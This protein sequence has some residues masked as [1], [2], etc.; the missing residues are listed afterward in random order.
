MPSR[1]T[2]RR[3]VTDEKFKQLLF[4]KMRPKDVERVMEAYREAED[5]HGR[6]SQRRDSG[7][8][9]FEHPK[10]VAMILMLEFEIYDPDMVISALLHDTVEDTSVFG[11]KDEAYEI[12]QRK[13]NKRVANFVIALSKESCS[14]PEKK[15][16]R[17]MRYFEAIMSEGPLTTI[18]KLA[19]KPDNL[20]SLEC[21]T[22]ERKRR[23]IAE[24]R[25]YILPMA[26]SVAER[27][28]GRIRTNLRRVYREM[29][30]ICEEVEAEIGL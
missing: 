26:K 30:A 8:M 19:D 4:L 3:Q 22:N 13:Y 10:R 14:D 21:Y 18:L 17:D 24:T 16:E 15:D 25:M 5:A 12:L 9:Y 2:R 23:Y 20:R 1:I 7:E 28:S 6:T 27:F 11:N 29:V